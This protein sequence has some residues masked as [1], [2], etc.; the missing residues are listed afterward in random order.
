[1]RVSR[2]VLGL[3]AALVGV[4]SSAPGCSSD[5]SSPSA[6]QEIAKNTIG[7]TGGEIDSSGVKLTIPAGALD[8]NVTITVATSPDPA[9]SDYVAASPV[10][11]FG[12]DGLTFAK[13]ITVTMAFTDDGQPVSAFWS[14]TTGNG[15]DDIG[16]TASAGKMTAQV[17]H[18]SQGF[19]GRHR[20]LGHAEAGGSD[21]EVIILDSSVVDSTA[22]D[23]AQSSSDA[24]TSDGATGTDSSSG[25]D[26]ASGSDATGSDSGSVADASDASSS[27][28]S[29]N[30]SSVSDAG[31]DSGGCGGFC[32]AGQTCCGSCVSTQTSS[33][34]CGGC[35][36][37]CGAGTCS[38]GFCTGCMNLGQQCVGNCCQG[39]VCSGSICKYAAG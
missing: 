29:S 22:G 19:V 4:L 37:S 12:P 13:P 28:D 31:V 5:D 7:A 9:P 15:F 24:N 11:V 25:S 35:G 34:N 18:F 26:S 16:G 30:D 3:G 20:A 32:A 36:I 33:T 6:P 8:R 10:F 27:S 2:F 14:T 17:T 39:L 23:D 38:N 1:M 21:V